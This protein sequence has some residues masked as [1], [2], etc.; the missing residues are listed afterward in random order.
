[1]VER[2]I[3]IVREEGVMEYGKTVSAVEENVSL[4]SGF[5]KGEIGR[6]REGGGWGEVDGEKGE[7]EKGGNEKETHTRAKGKR[8]RN[9][10][11][12]STSLSRTSFIFSPCLNI[13]DNLI[14]GRF[15]K[16][17]RAFPRSSL[18]LCVS[19]SFLSPF[20]G[21]SVCSFFL[22]V[23]DTR[24]LKARRKKTRYTNIVTCRRICRYTHVDIVRRYKLIV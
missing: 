9:R 23:D 20:S 22:S 21:V 13:K 3:V 18:S 15:S 16:A 6:R 8:G 1:M 24:A 2:R 7:S 14:I 4:P 11:N 10:R 5:R 12:G 19:L 17:G